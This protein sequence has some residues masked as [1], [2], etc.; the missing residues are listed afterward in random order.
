LTITLDN[1]MEKVEALA[2]AAQALPRALYGQW[3]IN[4]RISPTGQK[5][6]GYR[7]A[8]QSSKSRVIA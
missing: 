5:M 3:Q 8:I 4:A 6:L 7:P 2:N 1:A